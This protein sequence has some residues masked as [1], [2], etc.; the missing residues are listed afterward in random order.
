MALRRRHHRQ[1]AKFA[2]AGL[3]RCHRCE[4]R[5]RRQVAHFLCGRQ[6]ERRTDPQPH[7]GNALH[8]RG[9]AQRSGSVVDALDPG[10]DTARRV[11]VIGGIARA[12]IVEAQHRQAARAQVVGER[13]P[14]TMRAELL[15]AMG[16][17][18]DNAEIRRAL[19]VPAEAAVEGDR[20]AHAIGEF[21]RYRRSHIACYSRRRADLRVDSPLPDRQ[22]SCANEADT[23]LLRIR[24]FIRGFAIPC[25]VTALPLDLQFTAGSGD[26]ACDHPHRTRSWRPTARSWPPPPG[27]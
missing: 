20:V 26:D 14:M 1:H 23:P 9:R 8:P 11:V 4:Q 12:G 2:H 21:L 7:Q 16:C 18:Q 25:W 6:S 15:M 24:G 27:T 5:D 17:A 10:A 3:T 22:S 19:M 13:P